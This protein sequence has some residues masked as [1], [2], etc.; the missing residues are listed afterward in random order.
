MCIGD[1]HNIAERVKAYDPQYELILNP[2]VGKYQ[3]VEHRTRWMKEGDIDGRPLF[4]FQPVCEVVMTIDYINAEKEAPDQRIIRD[5]YKND[6]WNHPRGAIGFYDDMVAESEKRKQK[7]EEEF[8][9]RARYTAMD[10]H[11]YILREH[12]GM[13]GNKTIHEGVSV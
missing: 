13:P 11:K 6:W 4:S 8:N 7:R 5:L 9:D 10:R 3:V 2:H 12:D 1:I